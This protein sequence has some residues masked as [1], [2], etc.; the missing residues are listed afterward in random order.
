MPFTYQEFSAETLPTGRVYDILGHKLPS[1]TTVLSKTQS[2]DKV[3]SLL[4]WKEAL[5][6]K[7]DII[8]KEATENGTAVHELIE[9][10]LNGDPIDASAYSEKVVQGFNALKTKL[11]K[12]DEVWAQEKVLYSMSLGV[13]GRCD[14]VGVFRG[15]PSII[16]YKTSARIKS[17]EQIEDYFI[18][19]TAYA[20][21]HNEMFG[22]EIEN[23]VIIMSAGF[24]IPQEFIVKTD[25]YIDLVKDKINQY[26]ST[27]ARP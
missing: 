12:I 23:G 25:K 26:Y 19:V 5:G 13:A 11:K 6:E 10:F 21:M 16:D 7:A 17:R 3:D 15:K 4:R 20:M 22:T 27:Y 1:I 9:K 2:K 24:S 18:Q 14:C 8:S